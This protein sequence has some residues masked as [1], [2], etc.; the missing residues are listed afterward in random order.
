LQD[1]AIETFDLT[2]R[3]G[4]KPLEEWEGWTEQLTHLVR[5]KLQKRVKEKEETTA[6]DH[7]NITVKRAEFFGLLGPNGAGKTTLIKL[8]TCL[9]YP[10]E[11][12]ALVNGYDI[13]KDGAKVRAS[14]NVIVSGGW[15]GF[16][17]ALTVQQNLEFFARVY[18]LTKDLARERVKEVLDIL[19]LQ[20]K[21]S[22]VPLYLS[23]G[24]RQKLL[25]GKAFLVRAP[26]LFLDEPTI[27]LD[28]R[29]AYDVRD[30]VR[31]R[32]NREYGITVLM[33]TH[34][35]E[36]A[37]LLCDRVAIMHE[38][39]VVATDRPENLKSSV[40]KGDLLELKVANMMPDLAEK[41]KGLEDIDDAVAHITDPVSGVGFVRVRAPDSRD[42]L[43]DVTQLIE[44]EG[45]QVK[46]VK[47]VD[48]T[49]EDVFVHYTG[50]RLRE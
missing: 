4:I 21:R 37:D 14:M 1:Y 15:L 50:K 48:P 36:E 47:N 43:A 42:V 16:N 26:V 10:D 23:S 5:E 13:R 18:G 46:F 17:F 32:L 40:K 24:M 11:G 2:K 20:D 45:A 12:T 7:V 34:Y 31:K 19:G 28:P 49:L 6:V 39:K 29:A 22:E 41:I 30:F 8:L 35:M 3:F 27:G 44:K 9:L 38:G 25:L 33:S